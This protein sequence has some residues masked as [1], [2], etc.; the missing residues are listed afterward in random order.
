MKRVPIA[1]FGIYPTCIGVEHAVEAFRDAGF[2]SADISL[3][4]SGKVRAEDVFIEEAMDIFENVTTGAT[5]VATIDG[6]L[7]WLEEIDPVAS[8]GEGKYLA[9]GPIAEALQARAFDKS[10]GGLAGVLTSFGVPKNET[11]EYD[12]KIMQGGALLSVH[13]KNTEEADRARHLHCDV[14]GTNIFSTGRS[15]AES[16]EPKRSM[17]QWAGR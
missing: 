9:A 7:G 4:L 10:R 16:N 12:A 3:V 5:T 17:S 8:S 13:C 15:E 1:V 2:Q 14:G 6:P 11:R